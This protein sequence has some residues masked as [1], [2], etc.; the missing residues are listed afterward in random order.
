MR[1]R[2]RKKKKVKRSLT[3]MRM[4]GFP[5]IKS[6]ALG[7]VM[8]TLK[9]FGLARKPSVLFR[10]SLCSDSLERTYIIEELY[11]LNAMTVNI[12][13]VNV[14]GLRLGTRLN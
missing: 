3:L 6:R 2:E 10:S 14:T 4:W 11:G 8:A 7:R 1:E 5:T 13:Y 12:K 9:R